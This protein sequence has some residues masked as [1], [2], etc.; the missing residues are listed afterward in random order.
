M[1]P[2]PIIRPIFPPTPNFYSLPKLPPHH[3]SLPTSDANGRSSHSME[4]MELSIKLSTYPS[5]VIM[6]F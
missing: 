5:R 6:R 3:I 4:L 2:H 1:A